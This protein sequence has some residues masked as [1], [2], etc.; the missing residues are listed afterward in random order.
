MS[1]LIPT[2]SQ[3]FYALRF[4]QRKRNWGTFPPRNN[5]KDYKST[6]LIKIDGHPKSKIFHSKN[7]SYWASSR[8]CTAFWVITNV[9]VGSEWA[10]L[11]ISV[12]LRIAGKDSG[13]ISSEYHTINFWSTDGRRYQTINSKF[14]VT[15]GDSTPENQKRECKK[16][17]KILSIWSISYEPYDMDISIFRESEKSV[18]KWLTRASPCGQ[19]FWQITL[20]TVTMMVF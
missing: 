11:L 8:E 2:E 4:F 15:V 20:T 13:N 17:C 1:K 3:Q 9:H 18:L 10:P 19:N 7:E 16:F 6:H 12:I 14:K 5:D